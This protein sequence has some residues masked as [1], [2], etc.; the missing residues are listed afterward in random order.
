MSAMTRPRRPVLLSRSARDVGYGLAFVL[1]LAGLLAGTVVLYRGDLR[2]TVE[3]TVVSPRA[4]LTL[5]TGTAVKVRGVEVGTVE[6]IEP[7]G[8]GVRLTLA[9]ERDQLADIPADVTAQIVPPTAFGAK[10]VQLSAPARRTVDT[11]LAA[12]DTVRADRVTVEIDQTFQRLTG[13]LDAARPAQVNAALSALATALDGRGERI[14]RLVTRL[15]RYARALRPSLPTLVDD[16]RRADRVARVY[17]RALPD[18]LAAGQDAGTTVRTLQRQETALRD[19][20][21]GLRSF[22]GSTD[23]F[24]QATGPSLRRSLTE[25]RSTTRILARYAPELPCVIEGVAYNNGKLETVVGG[26]N[27]GITTF[28]R[29]QP[30]IGSYTAPRDALQIG[31][32]RGPSCYGLPVLGADEQNPPNPHFVIGT[33]PYARTPQTPT[34]DVAT[35]FFGALAGVL[36]FAPGGGR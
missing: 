17:D 3:V 5:A 8:D 22:S 23:A 18:L 1:L 2:N 4:G 32:T 26:L 21:A 11:P 30:A 19:L 9:V 20:L 34:E 15:D 13:V 10:Y 24:V 35:T 36:N 25:L 7:D 33:D 28:T 29:L 6:R 16:L 27:P 12:G 14:G 31:D